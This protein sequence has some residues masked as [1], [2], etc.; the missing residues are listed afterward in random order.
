LA[1][2]ETNETTLR[3]AFADLLNAQRTR[4]LCHVVFARTVPAA[5]F[6]FTSFSVHFTNCIR[7]LIDSLEHAGRLAALDF[8]SFLQTTFPINFIQLKIALR[9]RNRHDAY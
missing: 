6:V 9:T 8:H 3:R 1:K 7:A 4:L 5:L 2:P